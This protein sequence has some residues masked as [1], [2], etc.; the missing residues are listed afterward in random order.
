[1]ASIYNRTTYDLSYCHLVYRTRFFFIPFEAGAETKNGDN[2]LYLC[3]SLQQWSSSL[4]PYPARSTNR[5][6]NEG[7]NILSR[8]K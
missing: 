1:M 7:M 2:S 3:T 5:N 6:S 8:A 4:R